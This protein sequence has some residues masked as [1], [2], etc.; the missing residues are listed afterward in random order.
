LIGFDDGFQEIGLRKEKTEE[1]FAVVKVG[2]VNVMKF[3]FEFS[4]IITP[5]IIPPNYFFSILI[6]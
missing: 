6:K 5:K 4:Q 1:C 2:E 3:L